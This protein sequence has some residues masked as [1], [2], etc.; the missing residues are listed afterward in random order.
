MRKM[1]KSEKLLFLTPVLIVL[2]LYVAVAWQNW[3]RVEVDIGPQ[4]NQGIEERAAIRRLSQEIKKHPYTKHFVIHAGLYRRAV[5]GYSRTEQDPQTR[6]NGD[7]WVDYCFSNPQAKVVRRHFNAEE[8]IHAAASESGN[9]N[10]VEKHNR[11]LLLEDN[12][13]IERNIGRRQ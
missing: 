7:M 13:R 2:G 9:F 4:P 3:S 12:R 5:V 11:R 10:D 6:I 8:A 1:S